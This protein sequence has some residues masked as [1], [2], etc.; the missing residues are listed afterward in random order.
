MLGSAP[1]HFSFAVT[2]PADMKLD[3]KFL[4]GDIDGAAA[5]GS[6]SVTISNIA[7]N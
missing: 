1:E 4:L 5:L 6:H 7:W 2:A 3:L